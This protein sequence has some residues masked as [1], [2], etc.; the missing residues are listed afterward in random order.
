MPSYPVKRFSVGTTP[1]Q[2]LLA[3]ETRTQYIVLFPSKAKESGN[4]GILYVGVGF[5]PNPTAGS[6]SAGHSMQ[7]GEQ[8]GEE[9]SAPNLAVSKDAIYAVASTSSQIVEVY[10]VVG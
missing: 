3:K 1:V 6:L 10:E 8:F 4:T 9:V 5:V 7:A 2:L